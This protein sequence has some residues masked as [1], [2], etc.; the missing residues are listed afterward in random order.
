LTFERK[1]DRIKI[2]KKFH[3]KIDFLPRVYYTFGVARRRCDTMPT[4]M[5]RPK[6]DNPKDV[7]YS[8][9]LDADTEQRLEA[10]CVRRNVTKGAAIRE[11]LELLLLRDEKSKRRYV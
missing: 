5:G 10:Y 9:R 4:K 11:A 1:Y 7:R 8:I 3:K 6:V 2:W